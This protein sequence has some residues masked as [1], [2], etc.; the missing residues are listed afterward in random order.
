[1]FKDITLEVS[2]KPFKQTDNEYIHNVCKKIFRQWY[3]LLKNRE[4]ISV[5]L[6]TADGSEILDYSGNADD[7]FEWACYIGNA[8]KPLSVSDDDMERSIHSK[9]KFYMKNPPI[10]TYK[11]LKNIVAAF[12][13]EGQ[14]A[15]PAGDAFYNCITK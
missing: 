15:F 11:I 10:M 8:N 5:M 13:E 12:K 6:W 3:P 14:K 9:K 1:M 2:L 4:E 7:T